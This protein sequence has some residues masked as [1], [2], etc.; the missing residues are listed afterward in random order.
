MPLFDMRYR[1][2]FFCPADASFEAVRVLRE[3]RAIFAAG[4]FDMRVMNDAPD[5]T[6]ERARARFDAILPPL[7]AQSAPD[8]HHHHE[9]SGRK[10]SRPIY[11]CD[12]A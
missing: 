7:F 6:Y 5:K 9:S 3:Q 10:S 11:L 1:L 4:A 2:M 12:S 8:N